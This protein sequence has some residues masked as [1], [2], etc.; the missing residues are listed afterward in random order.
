MEST[1][2]LL[3]TDILINWLVEEVDSKTNFKLWE[4]PY[5]ILKK[6]ETGE[7]LGFITLINLM[8]IVFVL[9]RKKK[10]SER[11][12]FD[13]IRKIQDTDNLTVLVPDESDMISAYNLQVVF[14]LDPFNA[15][16]FGIFKRTCDYLISRDGEF[17]EIINKAENKVVALNPEEFLEKIG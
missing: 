9:R 8:E 14:P 7:L 4:A 13:V 11:K 16:Y 1:K 12:I 3:D 15:I 6:V 10:W 2:V 5:K 17:T